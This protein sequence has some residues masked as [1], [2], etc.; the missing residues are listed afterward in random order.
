MRARPT[1]I[2]CAIQLRIWMLL[3]IGLALPSLVLSCGEPRELTFNPPAPSFPPPMFTEDLVP[4][5]WVG[6]SETAFLA[7]HPNVDRVAA[8][9]FTVPIEPLAERDGDGDGGPAV[10]RVY[11]ES[12][13]GHAYVMHTSVYVEPNSGSVVALVYELLPTLESELKMRMGLH[14]RLT[15]YLG[16]QISGAGEGGTVGVWARDT[17]RVVW[18][19]THLVVSRQRSE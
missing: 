8:G 6:G 5:S 13:T 10:L 15:E 7:V 9:A 11:V 4:V 14:R 19:A 3:L 12:M 1:A 16:P 17:L 18:I 2:G